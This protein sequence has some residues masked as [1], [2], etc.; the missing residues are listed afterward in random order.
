MCGGILCKILA[1]IVAGLGVAAI[2][3][4]AVVGFAVLPNNI[5]DEV[6]RR[7]RLEYGSEQFQRWQILPFNQTAKIYFFEHNLQPDN[8][9]LVAERGPFVYKLTRQKTVDAKNRD[10]DTITYREYLKF[11]FDEEESEFPETHRL[12]LLNV[13]LVSLV[14][15]IEDRLPTGINS[16]INSAFGNP[17]DVFRIFSAREFLFDGYT[18]CTNPTA[19]PNLC[20]TRNEIENMHYIQPEGATALS[21]AFLRHRDNTFDGT[22]VITAG[23]DSIGDLGLIRTWNGQPNLPNNVWGNTGQCREIN[24]RDS[25]IFPPN[26]NRND[27]FRIFY[28]DICRTVTLEHVE[29][30]GFEG[31]SS[32][33]REFE[34]TTLNNDN[35]NDCY[36]TG[37]TR[38]PDGSNRCWHN[39]FTDLYT[40]TRSHVVLSYPHFLGASIVQNPVLGLEGHQDYHGSYTII[41][42]GTG[43]PLKIVK[44]FQYNMVLR[45]IGGVTVTSRLPSTIYP[46][47]WIEETMELPSN[48]IDKIHDKYLS[49]LNT[50]T[51]IT[52]A[53]IGCGIALFILGIALKILCC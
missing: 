30:V 40:C 8:R 21:F 25:T 44:R 45:N 34:E 31:I 33:R 1:F 41:E 13:P 24:G 23:M 3:I 46:V 18:F 12:K 16:E 43:T 9:I 17:E 10:D 36:C 5:R 38:L 22:Y 6:E 53:L 49:E 48:L 19:A 26:V 28:S 42:P 32:H 39:G 29:N 4:G 47:L 52:W 51:I 14:Q 11:D 7:V 15:S 2:I 20:P 50:I 35:D 27:D 37:Q